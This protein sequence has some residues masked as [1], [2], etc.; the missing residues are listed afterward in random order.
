MP[1]P[2]FQPDA[3]FDPAPAGT[4]VR[5]A[6]L[7][8]FV[9]VALVAL[10]VPVL[11]LQERHPPPWPAFIT[12]ELAP[13]VAAAIWFTARIRRYRVVGEELRVE[14]PLRI[15][16]YSLAGLQSVTADRE[17]LRRMLKVAGNAGLGS[18]NG[19]FRSKHLGPF[20]AYATDSEHAVVLRWLD[21]SLV[22]SPQQPSLFVEAVRKRA[23]LSR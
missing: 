18:I 22:I 1:A 16:R 5:L 19:R 23:G 14:L 13:V 10:V 21:R 11:M 8:T 2:R 17:A 9:A 20:R 7:L 4:R 12:V 6:T 3:V 15:V